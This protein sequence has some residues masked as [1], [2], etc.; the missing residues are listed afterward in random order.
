MPTTT[1]FVQ[2]YVLGAGPLACA[3]IGPAP[4]DVELIFTRDLTGMLAQAQVTGRQVDVVHPD[5]SAEA[6]SVS[7][8]PCDLTAN[9]LHLDGIEVTQ[10]IQDLSGSVP[11]IS[12]KRTV[13]RVYLG[14][15]TAATLTVQ[16]QLTVRQAPTDPAAVISAEATAA[17]DPAHAGDIPAQRNQLGRSLDF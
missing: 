10:A 15:H 2:S 11:L 14:N 16:G 8:T 5:D 1:G 17:L 13:V 3:M 6:S 4:D 12:G 7:F 9:P